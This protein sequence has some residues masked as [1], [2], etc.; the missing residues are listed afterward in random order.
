MIDHTGLVWYLWTLFIIGVTVFSGFFYAHV[1]A[2]RET[3]NEHREIIHFIEISFTVD[4]IFRFFLTYD[5][6]DRTKLKV[7]SLRKTS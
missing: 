1:A 6:N 3:I 2:F 7:I 5:E 4:L